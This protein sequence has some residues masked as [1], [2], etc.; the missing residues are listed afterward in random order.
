[1]KKIFIPKKVWTDVNSFLNRFPFVRS[2]LVAVAADQVLNIRMINGKACVVIPGYDIPLSSFNKNNRNAINKRRAQM[3]DVIIETGFSNLFQIR[4]KIR[5]YQDIIHYALSPVKYIDFNFELDNILGFDLHDFNSYKVLGIMGYGSDH[6]SPPTGRKHGRSRYPDWASE[7]RKRMLTALGTTFISLISSPSH[8]AAQGATIGGYIKFIP[9]FMRVTVPKMFRKFEARLES[10]WVMMREVYGN[11]SNVDQVP[12][13]TI[14]YTVSGTAPP[15]PKGV[16]YQNADFWSKIFGTEMGTAILSAVAHNMPVSI[17]TKVN[18]W[19]DIRKSTWDRIEDKSTAF[20]VNKTFLFKYVY[21]DFNIE[22]GKNNNI[23]V[24]YDKGTASAT[25]NVNRERGWV[26]LVKRVVAVVAFFVGATALTAATAGGT[27]GGTAVAGASGGTAAGA[28]TGGTIAASGAAA[29]GGGISLTSVGTAVG[30]ASTGAKL[31]SGG[32]S[33]SSPPDVSGAPVIQNTNPDATGTQLTGSSRL[34]N[35][36]KS[37]VERYNQIKP[38]LSTGMNLYSARKASKIQLPTSLRMSEIPVS[39]YDFSAP[40]AYADTG[41]PQ[42]QYDQYG[43]PYTPRKKM[44]IPVD[45][46]LI[47]GVGLIATLIL[48]LRR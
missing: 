48:T 47:G 45:Y 19:K 28:T 2:A 6:K 4:K 9:D 22:I 12:K 24:K 31:I 32:K 13:N 33:G 26:W 18:K 3:Q 20:K 46:F 21:Q 30:V 1:M 8:I 35:M 5:T 16:D 15:V 40:G 7:V 27:A 43:R 37:V 17:R 11:F 10:E 29:G 36:G 25:F 14:G 23:L 41:A 34:I 44:S 39:Q 42:I 38:L